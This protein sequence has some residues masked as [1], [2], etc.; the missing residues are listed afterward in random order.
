MHT[1]AGDAQTAHDVW[2]ATAVS[3]AARTFWSLVHLN[4]SSCRTCVVSL[5]V[6]DF[7]ASGF[8]AGKH[9]QQP[10]GRVGMTAV[11][12]DEGKVHPPPATCTFDAELEPRS[13]GTYEARQRADAEFVR[14]RAATPPKPRP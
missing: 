12:V 2:M 6:V 1:T 7:G 14:A 3:G 9:S 10:G 8:A 11:V 5:P 4:Q 13:D